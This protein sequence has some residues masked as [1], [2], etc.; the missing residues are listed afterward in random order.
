MKNKYEIPLGKNM[1]FKINQF[2]INTY[3]NC[4]IILNICTNKT[5]VSAYEFE[6]INDNSYSI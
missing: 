2:S 5:Y 1:K 3:L 6:T 4:V